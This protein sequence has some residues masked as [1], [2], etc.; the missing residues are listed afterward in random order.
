M[1]LPVARWAIVMLAFQ[2]IVPL[3]G[4]LRVVILVLAAGPL[5][6]FHVGMLVNNHHHVAHGLGIGL[7]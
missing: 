1:L 2:A 4:T 7:C 6:F 3:R 5:G